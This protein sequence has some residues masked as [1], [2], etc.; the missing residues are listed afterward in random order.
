MEG[1]ALVLAVGFLAVAAGLLWAVQHVFKARGWHDLGT[2]DRPILIRSRAVSRLLGS[3]LA[4]AGCGFVWWSWND[5]HFSRLFSYKM[6]AMGP[7]GIVLGVWVVVTGPIHTDD[8]T[9]ARPPLVAWFLMMLGLAAG[10]LYAH[11]L[12]TGRVFLLSG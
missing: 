9:H 8:S 10:F 6:A 1:V 7:C 2:P 12:E 5:A 11:F 4:L 3:L